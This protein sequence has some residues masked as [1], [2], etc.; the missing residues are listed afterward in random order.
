MGSFM[1]NT[2][3]NPK[4]E[5]K[6]I[7][8]KS[9]MRKN[10]E[11][12]KRDKGAMKDVSTEEGENKK[13]E[14][15]DKEKEKNNKRGEKV[16]PVKTKSQLARE[17]KREIPIALVKNIPYPLVPSKKE[18]ECYFARFLDIFKKLE[19]TILFGEALQQMP[20]Y[21]KFLMDL[22]TK[23]GKYINNESVVVKGNCDVVTQRILPQKFKDPGSRIE[24]LK[25]AP[26]RMMLQLADRS[27]TRPY[28]VIEDIIVKVR[29]FTF[30][31]DFVI[32]N[33]EE[34]Y[35]IPLILGHPFMLTT[36]CVMD[37]GN[38]NLEM[39]V[40][41]QKATFNLFEAIKHH[42]YNKNYF[43]VEAIEQE[44]DLAGR[45]LKSVFLE[46]DEVKPVV[47]PVAPSIVLPGPRGVK[48]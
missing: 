46:E 48:A 19:I 22:L 7:F 26:N 12:E 47:N 14:E 4:E 36:K 30:L 24:N 15:G 41:D 18:R 45:H 21:K 38:G 6:V 16:L 2:E 43:K 32:M 5:C 35:D 44:A 40:E 31:M 27:I 28:G 13:I 29:Q 11:K 10:V 34:N 20:M 9:Q 42:S 3:K 39:S 17:T 8:T 37:M 33:I 1:A 25:I 23:K